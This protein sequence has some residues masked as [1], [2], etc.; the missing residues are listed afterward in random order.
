MMLRED[1]LPNS[2]DDRLEEVSDRSPETQACWLPSMRLGEIYSDLVRSTKD[3][4]QVSRKILRELTK[5]WNSKE[6][7]LGWRQ[8]QGHVVGKVCM[9]KTLFHAIMECQNLAQ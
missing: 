5:L 1:E 6:D 2:L 7:Q 3:V 4:A 9:E 8:V